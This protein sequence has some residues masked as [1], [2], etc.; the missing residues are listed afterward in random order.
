MNV[1]K[2]GHLCSMLVLLVLG[3]LL[4]ACGT[5]SPTGQ[6]TQTM[7]GV[8]TSGTA[9]AGLKTCTG[10][11]TTETA[12]WMLSMH[13]N[14][15]P[16]GNL[17]SQGNPTIGQIYTN[18]AFTDPVTVPAVCKNCHDPQGDS[19]QLVANSTGNVVRP[20]V[21]C[22]ACHSGGALHVAKGGAG[23]IG[24]AT[25]TAMVI[26]T[27]STLQASAQLRTCTACHELL[28]SNDPVNTPATAAH[29][30]VSP[31]GSAFIITDTH[32]AAPATFGATGA[33]STPS[34][35]G[36]AMNYAS[37]KVCSNCHNPHGTADIDR[38]W[39]ASPHGNMSGN[40]WI[41]YNWSC[42]GTN[43]LGCGPTTTSAAPNINSRLYCQRCHTTTGYIAYNTA[44]TTGNTALFTALDTGIFPPG[45]NPPV[46]YQPNWKPEMLQCQGCHTD[47]RG[48]IRN[49]GPFTA[50]YDYRASPVGAP[51]GAPS[52]FYSHATFQ[53]PD[54]GAANLC[55][56]C[57]SGRTNGDTIK[58][59]NTDPTLPAADFSKLKAADGH[60]ATAAAVMFRGI[61]Y[62]YADRS[63]ENP[64][65][66]RHFQIGT[67]AVPNTGMDG[68][69]VGC[70]MFRSSG[71]ANH[72]F[73]CVS[74]SGTTVVSVSSEVCFNC[75]AGSS[76]SLASVVDAERLA[77][78]Y[79]LGIF[80]VQVTTANAFHPAMT[81]STTSW[82]APGDT[83]ISGNTTGK[84]NLGAYFNFASLNGNEMG[85]YVHNSTY[86]K[87]LIYDSIDWLDDGVLNYSV[88]ST[89][90]TFCSTATTT[91]TTGM[92]YLLPNGV[93]PGAASERP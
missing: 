1:L 58:N 78:T 37:E 77:Y 52:L 49:P 64:A 24:L 36:Y 31:T 27:T 11:H 39:A 69:C 29:S 28:D 66:Y 33:I 87:R 73:S 20:V 85:A 61:G 19:L 57:H 22:E 18:G 26:G 8:V 62:Q 34:I 92:N 21:G 45:L 42:D 81:S 13:G 32:F 91:C 41:H 55:V 71:P 84:S 17:Y 38:G 4:G 56:L 80:Q 65:A 90:Q 50:T 68:P 67:A 60:H 30:T 12:D 5:D 16:A 2:K 46:P 59:L 74:K 70:H 75:H 43:A 9:T 86:T 82:L 10:C 40:G 35:T 47:N 89:L 51:A 48:G 6:I 79:A 53:F 54:R 76:T 72:L 88:G 44:I 7:P 3:A 25:T 14:V 83:D 93:A 23:P 63:Y 15:S